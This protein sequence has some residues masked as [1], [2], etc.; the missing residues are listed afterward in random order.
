MVHGPEPDERLG[1]ALHRHGGP[2]PPVHTGADEAAH[3]GA[4]LP[5]GTGPV[6]V[7][8]LGEYVRAEVALGGLRLLHHRDRARE[9]LIEEG[10]IPEPEPG[11]HDDRHC[12]LLR[13]GTRTRASRGAHHR[14][15]SPD[16]HG[17]AHRRCSII[18]VL[19]AGVVPGWEGSGVT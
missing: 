2:Y 12:Y 9:K 19:S 10:G 15:A 14:P 18:Q 13:P 4:A 3:R 5:R 11:D 16:D 6:G 7:V 17:P 8:R 1:D